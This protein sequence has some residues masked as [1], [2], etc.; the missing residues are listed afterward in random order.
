MD[1][2][3]KGKAM[4]EKN[5]IINALKFNGIDEEIWDLY[6]TEELKKIASGK[7]FCLLVFVFL[8]GT[9]CFK[10]ILRLRC[11]VWH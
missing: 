6:T 4:E 10:A 9:S 3:G 11:L 1:R 2:I 7:F 5:L 8:L